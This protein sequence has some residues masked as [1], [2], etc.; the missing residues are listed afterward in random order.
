M[1]VY[2]EAEQLKKVPMLAR[3]DASK[4]KLLAFTSQSLHFEDGD[5]ICR[6][7]DVADGAYVIMHGEVEVLADSADGHQEIVAVRGSNE[8]IGEMAV[9]NNR[10]RN[11][12]LRAKG[13]VRALHIDSDTFI[14]LVSENPAVALD[15]MR[16]LSV[17]LAESHAQVE[18][19]LTT[20]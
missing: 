10:P 6:R 16:Q 11:A 3:L 8:L 17:R 19:L 1:D 7:D 9:L 2:Q 15:V 4:L 20:H 5:I 12:T 13:P 14:S 18:T